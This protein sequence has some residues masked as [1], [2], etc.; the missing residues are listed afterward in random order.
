MKTVAA[1]ALDVKTKNHSTLLLSCVVA[2]LLNKFKNQLVG[3]LI[4]YAEVFLVLYKI[5]F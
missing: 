5:D 2:V 3:L 4:T 1:S